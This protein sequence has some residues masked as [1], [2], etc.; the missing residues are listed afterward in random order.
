MGHPMQLGGE[1]QHIIGGEAQHI[2]SQG[3]KGPPFLVLVAG[4]LA[5]AVRPFLYRL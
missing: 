2:I 5:A 3:D 4:R 1:A